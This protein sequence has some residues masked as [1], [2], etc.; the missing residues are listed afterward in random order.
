MAAAVAKRKATLAAKKAAAAQALASGIDTNALEPPLITASSSKE[1]TPVSAGASR[2][3]SAPR[4]AG[5]I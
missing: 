2:E 5:T 3:Q 4:A 1:V